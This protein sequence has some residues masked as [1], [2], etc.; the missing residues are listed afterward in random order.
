M[1]YTSRDFSLCMA[2]MGRKCFFYL[3]MISEGNMSLFFFNV[4]KSF[5]SSITKSD[6][7]PTLFYYTLLLRRVIGNESRF[8]VEQYFVSFKCRN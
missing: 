4:V 8:H 1:V 7:E 2:H 3:C 6:E 5:S